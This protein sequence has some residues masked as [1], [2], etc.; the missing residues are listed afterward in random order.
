MDPRQLVGCDDPRAD[1]TVRIEGFAEHRRRGAHL[2][3]PHADI[4]ADHESRDD[5]ATLWT[6]HVTATAANDEGQFSL[7]VERV[8]PF[9]IVDVIVGT[10]DAGDLFVEPD[11]MLGRFK[12]KMSHFIQMRFITSPQGEKF[13][14]PEY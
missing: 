5:I 11:L 9:R 6:R 1:G 2:P 4:V 12:A 14:R 3:F 7:G 8:R 10:A 13:A